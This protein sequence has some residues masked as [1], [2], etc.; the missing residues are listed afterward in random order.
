VGIKTEAALVAIQAALAEQ[1]TELKQ[2]GNR[3]DQLEKIVQAQACDIANLESG[4]QKLRDQSI[5][6]AVARGVPSKVVAQAHG[7]SPGRVTQIAPRKT[8]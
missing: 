3:I 6:A 1:D 7:L 4:V 5:K 8:N 2:H